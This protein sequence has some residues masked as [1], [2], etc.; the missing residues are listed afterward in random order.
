MG[1]PQKNILVNHFQA[2][3]DYLKLDARSEKHLR[4]IELMEN[5]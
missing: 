2:V 3:E 4:F 5:R 1:L